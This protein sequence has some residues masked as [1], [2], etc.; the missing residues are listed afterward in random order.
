MTKKVRLSVAAVV[1]LVC[2]HGIAGA[3]TVKVTPLGAAAGE[4]SRL[5]R[6]LLFEDPTGV[7]IL[8]DPGLTV[9]ATDSRLGS[10]HVI[11]VSHGHGDHLG[12]APAIAA[13]KNAGVI[14]APNL[15][16]FIGV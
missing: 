9:S 11:L 3:Q 14:A 13:A 12:S 2:S 5:D 15:A 1:C 4:L 10:V 6:A 16:T 8:Y 7:R